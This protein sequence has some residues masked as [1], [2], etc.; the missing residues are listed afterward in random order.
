MEHAAGQLFKAALSVGL[1]LSGSAPAGTV[2][3]DFTTDFGPW[4]PLFS[5]E[6]EIR[7]D[8]ETQ[9]AAL[10]VPGENRSPVPRP[11]AYL[12]LADHTWQNYSITLVGMS[13]EPAETIRR[14]I[15]IIFGY[16]DDTHYYYAHISSLSDAVHNVIMKVEDHQRQAIQLETSP[17]P[18][19]DGTMQ[20]FRVDHA[21]DGTIM[22][23]VDDLT[24]PLMTANDTTFPVGAVAFGSFDDR[25]RFDSVAVSGELLPAA[26][27]RA[28]LVQAS[29]SDFLLRFPTAQGFSYQI[30]AATALPATEPDGTPVTGTGLQASVPI[31]GSGHPSR[32]FQIATQ[33]PLLAEPE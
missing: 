11:R 19:I 4:T 20:T 26:A 1:A 22:V 23:F 3:S 6:W 14:D 10:V 15:S 9:T 5:G 33:H 16:A 32:F 29:D 21:A 24:T 2:T 7:D 12:F 25:A 13:L 27:T 17:L 31:A 28:T 8:G 18:A 30:L